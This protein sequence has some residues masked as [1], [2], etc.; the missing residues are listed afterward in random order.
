VPRPGRVGVVVVV[1]GLILKLAPHA[2][3]GCSVWQVRQVLAGS[4][5]DR[6]KQACVRG[7]RYTPPWCWSLCVNRWV[8]QPTPTRTWPLQVASSNVA[9]HMIVEPV[10]TTSLS[11]TNATTHSACKRLKCRA[12]TDRSARTRREDGGREDAHGCF[13]E[14]QSG[15]NPTHATKVIS[16]AGACTINAVHAPTPTSYTTVTQSLLAYPPVRER[17]IC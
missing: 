10:N 8:C 6:C 16:L 7:A 3:P 17:C 15:L 2:L 1:H 12:V 4:Q 11:S 13:T 9:M 14:S 5:S